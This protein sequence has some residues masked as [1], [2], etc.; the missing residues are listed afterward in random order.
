MLTIL[1]WLI[2]R[3]SCIHTC[4]PRNDISR[5]LSGTV[6][7]YI[8]PN[9]LLHFLPVQALVCIPISTELAVDNALQKLPQTA[10]FIDLKVAKNGK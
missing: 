2:P 6:P 1:I 3:L 10:I 5:S 8:F 4:E 7:V 9:L